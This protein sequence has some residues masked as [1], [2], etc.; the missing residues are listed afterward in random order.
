MVDVALPKSGAHPSL[1]GRGDR[2]K[3]LAERACLGSLGQSARKRRWVGASLWVRS[4]FPI[5]EAI[6]VIIP[7]STG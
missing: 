4:Y 3:R 5:Q 1:P 6:G 2:H 7:N